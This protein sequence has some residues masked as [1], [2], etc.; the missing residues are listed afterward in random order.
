[1]FCSHS[2]LLF[3]T[4]SVTT[5][6]KELPALRGDS[7]KNLKGDLPRVSIFGHADTVGKDEL[8]KQ[9]SG[10][11]ATAIHGLLT[12]DVSTWQKLLN[13][14][15]PF[16]DDNWR[17]QNVTAKMREVVGDGPKGEAELIKAY[18]AAICPFQLQPT[19]DFLGNGENPEGKADFQGCSSF[20]PLVILSDLQNQS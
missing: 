16:G 9:L 10:R 4:Q 14:P 3:V 5:I 15:S 6:L 2:T 11:R 13:S 18:L 17:A 1:M 8:N 20:N 12:Q 7:H 19:T